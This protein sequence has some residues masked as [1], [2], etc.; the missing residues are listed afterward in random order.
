MFLNLICLPL[1]AAWDMSNGKD[2]RIKQCTRIEHEDLITGTDEDRLFDQID[3][4]SCPNLNLNSNL[5]HKAL[6][7]RYFG[8]ITAVLL[9]VVL[10]GRF[11][12]AEYN[13]TTKQQIQ[14]EHHARYALI[15]EA[16]I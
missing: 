16:Q 5:V 12:R 4:L 11:I 8:R 13:S 3:Y 14:N 10:P 2:V 9:M 1:D 6:R 15:F 7:D